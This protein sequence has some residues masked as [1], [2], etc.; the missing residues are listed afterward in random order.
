MV[1]SRV[2]AVQRWP[3]SLTNEHWP[4]SR[5]HT[6]RLTAGA[7]WRGSAE[8]R[9]ARG[10]AVA[11]NFSFSSWATSASSAR[12]S[13]AAR[14]PLGTAWPSRARAYSS[15]SRVLSAIV[16]WSAKRP[17]ESG[18]TFARGAPTGPGAT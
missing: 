5:S 2:R 7:M 18:F 13:T 15:L 17:G 10:R 3:P 8:E 11:A 16:T 9:R 12:S 14:S 6:A 4:P 1:S